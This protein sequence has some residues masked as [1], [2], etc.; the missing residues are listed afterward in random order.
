M[1]E[2]V[3]SGDVGLRAFR[4]DPDCFQ[5]HGVTVAIHHTMIRIWPT[6]LG[7]FKVVPTLE[8]NPETHIER[9]GII[10]GYCPTKVFLR[11]FVFGKFVMTGGSHGV[12]KSGR[13]L[14][15]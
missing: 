10:K 4:S 5:Q 11:R 8:M 9:A 6:F 2:I 3:Q 15:G 7:Y 12:R 1:L 13:E 14:G